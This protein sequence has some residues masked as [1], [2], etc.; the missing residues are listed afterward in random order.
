M[1]GRPLKLSPGAARDMAGAIQSVDRTGRD[2]LNLTPVFPPATALGF[3]PGGPNGSVV[4]AAKVT[5]SASG[6]SGLH[7]GQLYLADPDAGPANWAALPDPILI[8]PLPGQ[9]LAVGDVGVAVR[10][11]AHDGQAVYTLGGVGA[12]PAAARSCVAH[13]P[14]RPT[15]CLTIEV[16]DRRGYCAAGAGGESNPADQTFPAGWSAAEGGWLGDEY[17]VTP[18]G[19][20]KL[21]IWRD[22]DGK[23]QARIEVEVDSGSGPETLTF[24]GTPVGCEAASGSD[25]NH[26]PWA[27]W[28]FG[29]EVLCPYPDGGSGSEEPDGDCDDHWFVVKA[30]CG[31]CGIDRDCC[32]PGKK[33]PRKFC[34]KMTPRCCPDEARVFPVRYDPF[35]PYVGTNVTTPD[36]LYFIEGWVS[37]W[38]PP[39]WCCVDDVIEAKYRYGGDVSM[40]LV[41]WRVVV[42]DCLIVI[43]QA[44]FSRCPG[45]ESWG[46]NTELGNVAIEN[47]GTDPPVPRVAGDPTTAPVCDPVSGKG[48][49]PFDYRYSTQPASVGKQAAPCLVTTVSPE[50]A[51][52][53]DVEV[54]PTPCGESDPPGPV[55][56]GPLPVCEIPVEH[57]GGCP[58]WPYSFNL[59]MTQFAGAPQV[60]TPP[61]L[62]VPF[63]TGGVVRLDFFRGGGAVGAGDGWL[64]CVANPETYPL[65]AGQAGLTFTT[66]TQYESGSGFYSQP[67]LSLGVPNMPPEPYSGAWAYQADPPYDCCAPITLT[68]RQISGVVFVPPLPAGWPTAVTIT[69]VGLCED[70]GPLGENPC[71][72]SGGSDGGSG[73]S[74]GCD[75]PGCSAGAATTYAYD[76]SGGTGTFAL[77]VGSGELVAADIGGGAIGWSG[78]LTTVSP[79]VDWQIF[80]TPG[81]PGTIRITR[82]D[83]PTQV[84]AEYE[85]TLTDGCCGGLVGLTLIDVGPGTTGDPPVVNIRSVGDCTCTPIP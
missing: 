52:F 71:S 6:G 34:V 18:I 28:Q 64:A 75:I 38:Q 14:R 65:V 30:R 78:T 50:S 8:Q 26:E 25:Q 2:N 32:E 10:V 63:Y 15:Q 79:G 33:L 37:D 54:Y 9:T 43:L 7:D 62:L 44:K 21:I 12:E 61:S 23:Y 60:P 29:D 24:A 42:I 47:F 4:W 41:A 5:S 11:G 59:D 22:A 55:P 82:T 3:R 80:V 49:F 39:P 45:V 13:L 70:C 66:R 76:V 19:P 81:S 20:G 36:P 16:T 1:T 56:P 46:Y 73:S 35:L 83:D 68:L 85:F 72:G 69:P 58:Y 77:A 67:C 84:Y 57:Q 74:G 27:A 48:V 53:I 40:T 51:R 31:P 17:V